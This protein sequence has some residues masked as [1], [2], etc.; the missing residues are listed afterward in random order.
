MPRPARV[1][2]AALSVGAICVPALTVVALT[3]E[4][5]ALVRRPKVPSAAGSAGSSSGSSSSG[6]GDPWWLPLAQ[7]LE[8]LQQLTGGSPDDDELDGEAEGV[9]QEEQDGQETGGLGSE[10]AAEEASL[11]AA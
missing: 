4:P 11:G 8:R 6:A 7:Q 9:L 2:W 10:A 5:Q 1:P 3:E